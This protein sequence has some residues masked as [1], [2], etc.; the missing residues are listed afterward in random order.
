MPLPV[1]EGS[2]R[3]PRAALEPFMTPEPKCDCF[4]APPGGAVESGKPTGESVEIAVSKGPR[5]RTVNV[6][7]RRGGVTFEAATFA[8][9]NAERRLK[10]AKKAGVSDAIILAKIEQLR[11]VV[12]P[13]TPPTDSIT[14]FR[15]TLRGMEQTLTETRVISE[16]SPLDAL[17]TAL[18]VLDHPAPEPVIEWL[19]TEKLACLDVDYHGVDIGQRPEPH[20]LETLAARVRRSPG[21]LTEEEFAWPTPRPEDSRPRNLLP[22]P[23]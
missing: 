22:V 14:T 10:F 2:G 11:E 21:R 13:T 17:R 15:V 1:W 18:E 8:L 7:A 4:A 19:G 16:T 12:T 3:R 5:K 20:R 9:D 6:E 23:C